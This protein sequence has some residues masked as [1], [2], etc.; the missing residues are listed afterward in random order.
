VTL[1]PIFFFFVCFFIF[2]SFSK[3]KKKSV[4]AEAVA[5][6]APAPAEVVVKEEEGGQEEEEQVAKK[7]KFDE[8]KE[9]EK[10]K[11]EEEPEEEEELI[12]DDLGEHLPISAVIYP[13]S[14]YTFGKGKAGKPFCTFQKRM[15]RHKAVYEKEGV[16]HT[17]SGVL[18]C[19]HQG[20][21]TVLLLK[22]RDEETGKNVFSLPESRL[23][24]GEDVNTGLSRCLN[25][26]ISGSSSSDYKWQISGFLGKW[27]RPQ[28]DDLLFP[29][30]LPHVSSPK[31]TV[32]IYLIQM[33]K[34]MAFNVNQSAE[35]VAVPVQ[36]LYKDSRTYGNVI[37]S[38]PVQMARFS[39]IMEGAH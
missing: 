25:K 38:L 35:M 11:Q 33:P 15:I 39:F 36:H 16:R 10:E 30:D 23:R 2:F 5:E 37:S 8:G 6:P 28:F 14:S 19:H 1:A 21:L 24:P 12:E 4:M 27:V 29:Y 17:V 26:K 32:S 31:E 34:E 9:E 22:K 20:V 18:V 3:K 7:L 13:L